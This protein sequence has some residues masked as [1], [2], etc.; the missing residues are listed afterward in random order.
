MRSDEPT[1]T[2]AIAD[3]GGGRLESH[4]NPHHTSPVRRQSGVI[5]IEMYSFWFGIR[6][7]ILIHSRY[8]RLSFVQLRARLPFSRCFPSLCYTVHSVLQTSFNSVLAHDPYRVARTTDV[9]CSTPPRLSSTITGTHP[10]P[11]KML[12]S[13][14]SAYIELRAGEG[15]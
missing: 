2:R 8:L 14:A 6:F 9:L 10:N 7:T 12:D 1:C 5:S 4:Y 15:R 13:C 3:R 11:F